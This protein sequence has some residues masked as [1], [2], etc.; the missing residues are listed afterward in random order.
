V[1]RVSP[2]QGSQVSA[3]V[4]ALGGGNEES[5]RKGYDDL[6]TFLMEHLIARL[7]LRLRLIREQ[8]EGLFEGSTGRQ[9]LPSYRS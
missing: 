8:P 5:T 4:T 3:R 1:G 6:A 7:A 2:P 9:S